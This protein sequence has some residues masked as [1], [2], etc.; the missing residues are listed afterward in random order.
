MKRIG[1]LFFMAM[2]GMLILTACMSASTSTLYAPPTP[3]ISHPPTIFDIDIDTPASLA[4]TRPNIITLPMISPFYCG[5]HARG[6]N[7]LMAGGV[8]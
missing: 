6:K 3:I 8:C 5:L 1:R 7:Q 4:S 2:I